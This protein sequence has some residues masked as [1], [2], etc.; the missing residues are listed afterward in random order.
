MAKKC[1]ET[2]GNEDDEGRCKGYCTRSPYLNIPEEE[3]D[4]TC[5]ESAWHKNEPWDNWIEGRSKDNL[6]YRIRELEKKMEGV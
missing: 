2:C 1:C 3:R 5:L 6:L 4:I